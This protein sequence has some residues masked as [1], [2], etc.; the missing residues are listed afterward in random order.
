VT[1]SAA[2][3]TALK[4]G[5]TIVVESSEQAAPQPHRHV[6]TIVDQ[7]GHWGAPPLFV[8]NLWSQAG[9][10][11]RTNVEIYD[12]P[13]ELASQNPPLVPIAGISVPLYAFVSGLP[14]EFPTV[15]SFYPDTADN[16]PMFIMSKNSAADAY[17]SR[18]FCGFEVYLLEAVSHRMLSEYVLVRHFRLGNPVP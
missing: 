13:S 9:T 3:F 11:G 5:E 16:Q 7:V 12:M 15:A 1:L 8:S 6:F 2:D 4:H 17:F 10:G 14:E 18:A